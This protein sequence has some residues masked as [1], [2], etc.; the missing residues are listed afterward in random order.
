MDLVVRGIFEKFFDKIKKGEKTMNENILYLKSAQSMKELKQSISDLTNFR[1]KIIKLEI[2][3][4]MIGVVSIFSLSIISFTIPK[5]LGLIIMFFIIILI[6]SAFSLSLI[7]INTLDYIIGDLESNI[8]NNRVIQT[9]EDISEQ[10]E[11]L[12]KKPNFFSEI[13]RIMKRYLL[14][15]RIPR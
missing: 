11:N 4:W 12:Q 8:K 9:A 1:S 7:R 5:I 10:I 13:D 14:I 3:L 15:R 6:L 2:G